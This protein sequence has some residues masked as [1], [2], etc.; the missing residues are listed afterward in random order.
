MPQL[1]ALRRP[2][3]FW[4]AAAETFYSSKSIR[5]KQKPYKRGDSLETTTQYSLQTYQNHERQTGNI[6]Y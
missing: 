2:G 1:N 5:R 4:G 6:T 3:H